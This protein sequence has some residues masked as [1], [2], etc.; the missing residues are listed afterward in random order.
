MTQMAVLLNESNTQSEPDPLFGQVVLG[1]DVSAQS[2]V[3]G[4]STGKWERGYD[5]RIAYIITTENE[6]VENEPS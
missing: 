1:Y 4:F 3:H 2:P 6:V 5:D